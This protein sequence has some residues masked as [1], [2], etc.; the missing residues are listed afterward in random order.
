VKFDDKL[1][2]IIFE[3][4]FFRLNIVMHNTQMKAC[5]PT[6]AGIDLYIL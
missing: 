3:D 1:Q 5:R 6:I 2:K 4:W